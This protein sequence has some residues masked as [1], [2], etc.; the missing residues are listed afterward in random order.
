MRTATFKSRAFA[1]ISA[2]SLL[3]ALVVV[4][5]AT[6]AV[7]TGPTCNGATPVQTCT[8]TTSD[9]ALYEMRVPATFNGTVTIWSHGFGSNTSFPA[10]G[11]T[12]DSSA[13]LAPANSAALIKYLTDKGVA[14]IGSGFST[15]GWNLDE[16]VKTNAELIGIF[17][18]KFTDTKKVVAWGYSMGGGITQALAEQHPE[19][20]SAAAVMNPVDAWDA[21]SKYFVDLLWLLK[22]WFDPSIQLTGY[23]A[24]VAGDIQMLG[25]ISKYTAILTSLQAS[26]ATGAWPSTSSASAKALQ[27]AGIPSRSALLLIGRLAGISTQSSSFDGIAGPA[28]S[29]VTAWPLA[30]APALGTLENISAVI[31]YALLGARDM[32]SKMGGS[33]F[34]NST[35]DYSKQLSAADRAIYNAGLS[36]NTAIA[37]MLSTLNPLNPDAPRIKA[38]AAALAMSKATMYQSTGKI[39]VPTVVMM[40]QNDPVEPAGIVQRM[41]DLYEEDFAAAK[42]AAKAAN[43]A[44][45]YIAPRRQLAVLWSVTPKTW[46]KFTAD[47]LPIPIKG[48]PGTGHTNFTADEYKFVIDAALTAAST[49]DLPRKLEVNQSLKKLMLTVDRTSAY[50]WMK[51]YTTN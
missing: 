28:T 19:L 35:T 3:A 14:V 51:R 38:D 27:A 41:A 11:L 42:E 37:G 22:N 33:N 17:K 45:G 31:G 25:D 47:G 39:K 5:P 44:T 21:Q 34:D 10:A 20:L 9:G 50:P 15:Q 12:I 32:Q 13:Q 2:T 23:K 26:V 30:Y 46:S 7:A 48:T 6:A 18:T 36:G 8:G 49:G 40:G 4:S 16:A 43:H 29:A 1:F 24:G